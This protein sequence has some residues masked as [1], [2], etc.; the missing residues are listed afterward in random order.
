MGE[1][2]EAG[3]FVLAINS[4]FRIKMKLNDPEFEWGCKGRKLSVVASR[5]CKAAL[6]THFVL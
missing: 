5:K 2:T 1:K 3:Q 4:G 6:M